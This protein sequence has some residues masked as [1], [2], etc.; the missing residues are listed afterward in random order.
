MFSYFTAPS[1]AGDKWFSVGLASSFP[2]LG[3]DEEEVGVLSQ[4]RSCGGDNKRPGC[5]AFHVPK[6]D[7]SKSREV[8]II[9]EDVDDSS[10]PQHNSDIGDESAP[11]STK[12]EEQ[13]L[14]FR[15]K[16]KFHAVD[17]SC[18]HSSFPLSKGIPFD[19]EDFGV[20][21]SAGISCPKHGW[22]F[23]LFTGM[24]DRGNYRLKI[25]EVELRDVAGANKGDKEDKEV[26]VRRKQRMG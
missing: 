21:L 10:A 14:V 5:K 1:R 2:D 15:Y 7:S 9:E 24:S 6:V 26:W 20:I 25:W 22:S 19:I 8:P 3:Q 12:L 4:P 17:H 23:D 16:G 11:E 13:V 18:P